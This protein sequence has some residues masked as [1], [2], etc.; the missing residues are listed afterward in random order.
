MYQKSKAIKVM[1][2]NMYA[3]LQDEL[4]EQP[5]LSSK[6]RETWLEAF[7]KGIENIDKLFQ[8]EDCRRLEKSQHIGGAL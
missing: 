2:I 4:E 6:F 8:G 1:S 3:M 5:F 7:D